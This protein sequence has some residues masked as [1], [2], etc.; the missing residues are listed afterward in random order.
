MKK[1]WSSILSLMLLLF[2]CACGAESN[3]T[4][5]ASN[6]TYT[7]NEIAK[8][9]VVEFTLTR[10]EY[11][12]MLKNASFETG[13]APDPEYLLP[14]EKEQQNNPFIAEDGTTMISFSYIF[15]NSGKEELTFP[16][17]L[18][19]T[20]DYNNGYLFDANVNV[21]KGEYVILEGTTSLPPLRVLNKT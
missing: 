17:N 1:I 18:G 20:V 16:V 5:A 9:D 7:L 12:Q 15:K 11:A 2:L 4:T 13:K 10:F 14:T 21:I 19:I 3:Q 6:K 8:T